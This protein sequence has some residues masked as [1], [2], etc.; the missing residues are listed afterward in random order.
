[1]SVQAMSWVIEKSAQK[2]SNLLVLLMIANHAHTDGRGA[3]P[4][5]TTLAAE[6]RLTERAVQYILAKLE[7]SSELVIERDAGPRGTHLYSLPG[8]I[9]DG[10]N[11]R[12]L[13]ENFSGRRQERR[14]SSGG[15][16]P[17]KFAPCCGNLPA[18][19]DAATGKSFAPE[20]N[21]TET[22]SQ[23]LRPLTRPSPPACGKVGSETTASPIEIT[24]S[25]EE[26]LQAARGPGSDDSG[27]LRNLLAVK[28]KVK[29][30][31]R[32]SPQQRRFAIVARLTNAAVEILKRDPDCRFGDLS[33]HLK[34][35]AADH[36]VAYFDGWP[37]AATPIQQAITIAI[38]R[39]KT[40]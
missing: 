19:S 38:E 5:I 8:V 10:F 34:Q 7:S 17:A 31:A 30:P 3:Y 13:P 4:A 21:R 14:P 2:G 22:K 16:L 33:E 18:K 11:L 36:D 1:M 35:W 37:G 32:V 9:R 20:P 26:R 6:A 23:N 12:G 28:G 40:A 27:E 39:R 29:N 25:L 24:E 15:N